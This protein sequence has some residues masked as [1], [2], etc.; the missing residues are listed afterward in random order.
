MCGTAGNHS[1]CPAC[2]ISISRLIV[3]DGQCRQL[4]CSK[5]PLGVFF[6]FFF[7][8]SQ[9]CIYFCILTASS[10]EIQRHLLFSRTACLCRKG[11]NERSCESVVTPPHLAPIQRTICSRCLMSLAHCAGPSALVFAFSCKIRRFSTR[12]EERV[13]VVCMSGPSGANRNVVAV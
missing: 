5:E 11:V 10:S 12:H 9:P 7:V 1:H 4:N 3:R 6:F 13:A 8:T 2:L